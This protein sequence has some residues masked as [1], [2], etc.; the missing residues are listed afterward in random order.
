MGTWTTSCPTTVARYPSTYLS[1]LGTLPTWLGILGSAKS[2][3]SPPGKTRV[4]LQHPHLQQALQTETDLPPLSATFFS[5]RRVEGVVVG[6]ESLPEVL[7]SHLI[8]AIKM[9]RIEEDSPVGV[10]VE[11]ADRR[12]GSY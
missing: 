8:K 11:V 1:L 7:G 10:V 6:E 4:N 5:S 2:S 12:V 3:M 9:V